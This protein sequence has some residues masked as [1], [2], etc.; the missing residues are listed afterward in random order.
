V[1]FLIMGALYGIAGT[2]ITARLGAATPSTGT[3]ME[4][5]AIAGAVI[6][7]TSL[8]G[9]VGTVAGAMVGCVLLTTIDNGMSI[10]NV[11]S[12]IQLIVKGVVLLL[13]LSIDAYMIRHR[14][15]QG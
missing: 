7:G 2:L 11:S 8:R 13:A 1:G 15:Y 12:F 4:L 3:Y 6:G 14:R 5:D 9:G 10:M